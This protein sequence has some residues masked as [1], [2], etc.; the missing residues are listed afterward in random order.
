[1]IILTIELGVREAYGVYALAKKIQ[2]LGGQCLVV[3]RNTLARLAGILNNCVVVVDGARE[4]RGRFKLFKKLKKNNNTVCLYDTEGF[5][6]SDE[7]FELRYP[8]SNLKK[9]D[10]ILTWGVTTH[11]RLKSR[12]LAKKLIRFGN[13]QFSYFEEKSKEESNVKLNN[14]LLVTTKFPA[15]DVIYA[16]APVTKERKQKVEKDR[17]DFMN[18][19][20]SFTDNFVIRTHPNEKQTFY[21]KKGF[22]IVDNSKTSSFENILSVDTVIGTNCTTL[23]EAAILGKNTINVLLKDFHYQEIISLC[24]NYLPDGTY[25]SGPE[26]SPNEVLFSANS[27][28]TN[29]YQAEQ[30]LFLDSKKIF[31]SSFKLFLLK[32]M[33]KLL[34]FY[35][36]VE[37]R[38]Y[39]SQ[40]TMKAR[41]NVV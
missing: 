41:S 23:V 8:D 19:V 26:K 40:Y 11:E 3:P 7:K 10:Y 34:K 5:V 35:P 32:F 13:P 38:K 14:A 9:I 21:E 31:F 33:I 16:S 20:K 27:G 36:L 4:V 18:F 30:L 25:I 28:Y 37:Y 15:A 29:A 1:M 2:N 12:G 17:I 22:E 39:N 24:H 6:L